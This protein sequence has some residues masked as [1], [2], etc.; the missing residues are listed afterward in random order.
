MK[1][2][3]LFLTTSLL[4]LST[5]FLIFAGSITPKT[6]TAVPVLIILILVY[7][8]SANVIALFF[9][10]YTGK[11]WY[12]HITMT[13]LF[14]CVPPALIMFASLRQA[15]VLD[16]FILFATIILIAWYATYKK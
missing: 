8:L 2:Q 3:I 9:A 7:V 15:T 14:A 4:S 6:D 10:L 13:F 5:I 16:L 12:S 1:K 11:S